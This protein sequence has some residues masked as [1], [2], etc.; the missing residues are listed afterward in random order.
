MKAPSRTKFITVFIAGALLAG[1]SNGAGAA[2]RQKSPVVVELFTSQGCYSCPPAEAYLRELSKNPEIVAL[3]FHVDYWDQ[4]VHGAAG[5]WKDV[6]SQPEFTTRQKIYAGN[7]E[8]G[9]VYT[10]Q[11]V[12]DGE[13]FAVGSRRSDVRHLISRAKKIKGHNPTLA[14][15]RKSKNDFVATI[16]GNSDRAFSVWLVHFLKNVATRVRAGENKGKRLISHNIVTK[17]KRLAAWSGQP[18][19]VDFSVIGQEVNESCAVLIQ[20]DAQGPI[21]AAAL[22]PDQNKSG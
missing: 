2:E 4:L 9:Q 20:E 8:G 12:V 10:P 3:E 19:K 15:S 21:Y 1:Y 7:L 11:M 5:K 16:K 6:F 18:A 17:V 22:C 14:I 13:N